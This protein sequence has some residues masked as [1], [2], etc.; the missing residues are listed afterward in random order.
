MKKLYMKE[1]F[2]FKKALEIYILSTIKGKNQKNNRM[3]F[4]C[5]NKQFLSSSILI[6]YPILAR[7]CLD[8]VTYNIQKI[9]QLKYFALP[10]NRLLLMLKFKLIKG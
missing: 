2:T 7:F 6:K 1:L 3:A 9:K 5:I 10:L 4:I 8:K